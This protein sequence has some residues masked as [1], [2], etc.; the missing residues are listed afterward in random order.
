MDHYRERQEL[1]PLRRSY[2]QHVHMLVS[3]EKATD[4][5]NYW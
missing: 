4:V 5:I 1:V 2:Y 3:F